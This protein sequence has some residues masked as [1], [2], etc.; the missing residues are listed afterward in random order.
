MG[1]AYVDNALKH[2]SSEFAQPAQNLVTEGAWGTI[3]TRTGL[4][5]QQRS[6]C[7]IAILAVMG[8]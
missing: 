4:S 1:D 6:L 3:W 7:N 5:Y 2:N 8:K